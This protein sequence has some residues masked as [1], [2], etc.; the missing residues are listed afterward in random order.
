MFHYN[1]QTDQGDKTE[2]LEREGLKGFK[3]VGLQRFERDHVKKIFT[4]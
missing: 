1:N 2:G 3:G 4:V